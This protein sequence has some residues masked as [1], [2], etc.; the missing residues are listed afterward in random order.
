[1]CF[2]HSVVL[3]SV[4][5]LYFSGGNKKSVDKGGRQTP[6]QSSSASK[7]A[8]S[9]KVS[10]EITI[11]PQKKSTPATAAS[12]LTNA[13]ATTTAS[14]PAASKNNVRMTKKHIF[15]F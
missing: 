15:H 12:S 1:L 10:D 14:V 11:I 13:K 6:Q 9:L 5:N 4:F 3:K 8:A 2:F 7:I